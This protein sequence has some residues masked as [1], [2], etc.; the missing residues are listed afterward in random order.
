M[1][2]PSLSTALPYSSTATLTMLDRRFAEFSW[3]VP[4]SAAA[5]RKK[6]AARPALMPEFIA[7]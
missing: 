4:A 7:E 1:S 3:A 5:T 2:F 6:R